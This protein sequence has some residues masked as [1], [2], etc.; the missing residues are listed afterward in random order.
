MGLLLVELLV[1]LD[2]VLLD[3][4]PPL[5]DEVEAAGVEL[6]PPPRESVR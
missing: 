6:E 5:L 1:L 2:G 3:E 4:L